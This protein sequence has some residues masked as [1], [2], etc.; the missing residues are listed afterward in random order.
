[1]SLRLTIICE[2]AHTGLECG[3][4]TSE[5]QPHSYALANIVS[6]FSLQLSSVE[7]LQRFSFVSILLRKV[8]TFRFGVKEESSHGYIYT[9]F[10]GF[11]IFEFRLL[12]K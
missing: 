2:H 4:N 10:I 3:S 5:E 12:A 11:S 1:M 7:L 9:Y 8:Y 6:Q